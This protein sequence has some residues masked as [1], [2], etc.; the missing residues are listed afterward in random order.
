MLHVCQAIL[1][2]LLVDLRVFA[3][4]MGLRLQRRRRISDHHPTIGLN[5]G[6][7]GVFFAR[8]ML[9][10]GQGILIIVSLLLFSLRFLLASHR[11]GG[12]C[13]SCVSEVCLRMHKVHHFPLLNKSQRVVLFM[14]LLLDYLHDVLLHRHLTR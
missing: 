12:L 13:A 5:L 11:V 9:S 2:I 8:Q 3:A 10:I 7:P 1:V 4:E 14:Y 6:Q